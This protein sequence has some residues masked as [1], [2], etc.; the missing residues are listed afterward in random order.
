M[1]IKELIELEL[2]DT[3]VHQARWQ[4]IIKQ[5]ILEEGLTNKERIL[6]RAKE[7]ADKLGGRLVRRSVDLG[8]QWMNGGRP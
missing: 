4:A 8:L 1:E 2:A 7:E 6:E 3:A 5:I